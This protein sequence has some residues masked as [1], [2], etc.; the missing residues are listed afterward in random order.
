MYFLYCITCLL[1][2]ILFLIKYNEGSQK[3]E[4]FTNNSNTYA[5]LSNKSDNPWTIDKPTKL[6]ITDILRKIINMINHKTGMSYYF[7][8][9]DQLS[10]EVVCS[11]RTRFTADFFVHEMRNLETRKII[12]IFVVNFETRQ[13]DVEHINLSNAFKSPNKVFMDYPAPELIIQDNSLLKNEYHIMGMNDSTIPFSILTDNE[14]SSKPLRTPSEFYNVFLPL[15][16]DA[17]AQNPQA[18][19]PS[20][21]SSLYWDTNGV[22]ILEPQ[23][24]LQIGVNNSPM[25]LAPTPFDNPTINRQREWDNQYKPMF[26]LVNSAGN[27][28]G[29]G[30]ASSP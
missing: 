12:V 10:Q 25:K 22:N 27:G 6:I 8:A 5:D 23:T 1:I 28:S 20:R 17:A 4:G 18:L 7:T 15:S 16:I 14:G 24:I 13:V 11:K 29:R 19:F 3:N 21:R 30:V 9:Y 26:D 2:L